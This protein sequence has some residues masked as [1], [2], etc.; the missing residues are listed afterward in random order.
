M[1]LKKEFETAVVNEPSV[2]EPLN[3]YCIRNSSMFRNTNLRWPRLG[4]IGIKSKI[5]TANAVSDAYK[6]SFNHL[7]LVQYF[8]R[9]CP[10]I[11]IS[12]CFQGLLLN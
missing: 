6:L 8:V 2:F 10:L 12:M 5:C 7:N 4:L 11:I 1:G 3:V 9:G